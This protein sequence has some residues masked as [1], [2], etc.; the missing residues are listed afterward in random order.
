MAPLAFIGIW[1]LLTIVAVVAAMVVALI[2]ILTVVKRSRPPV[3]PP[4]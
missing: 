4:R 3:Q 2:V 1:E